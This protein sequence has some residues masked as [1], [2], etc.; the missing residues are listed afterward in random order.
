MK[1]IYSKVGVFVVAMLLS[2]AVVF[3]SIPASAATLDYEEALKQAGSQI[4]T[5]LDTNPLSAEEIKAMDEQYQKS[6]I[7][8]DEIDKKVG[9]ILVKYTGNKTLQAKAVSVEKNSKIEAM[10]AIVKLF[11]SSRKLETAEKNALM[12]FLSKYA[13]YSGNQTLI[14]KNQNII[15]QQNQD[16]MVVSAAA[17]AT[18]NRSAASAYAQ[19]YYNSYNTSIYPDLNGPLGGDC[20]NFISQAMKAGGKAFQDNW[21]IYKKNSTYTH[22]TTVDQ[23]NYSW[24][25]AAPSPWISAKEFTNYWTSRL[26]NEVFTSSYVANNQSAIWQKPYLRGDVIQILISRFWWY[27][28]YHTMMITEYGNN[29]YLMTYHTNNKKN[30]PLHSIAVSAPYNSSNYKFEFYSVQ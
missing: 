14:Q 27:E 17:T 22:P 20:T 12:H 4:T 3:P 25:L 29:D 30:N 8:E 26:T 16:R 21:Y 9:A 11:E 24:T 18:Y 23:L 15:S 7:I 2:V 5:T 6:L 10:Q 1:H 28:G 13:P 19:Q